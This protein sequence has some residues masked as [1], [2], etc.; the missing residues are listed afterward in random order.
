MEINNLLYSKEVVE[1]SYGYYE[2][3][4]FYGENS[5]SKNRPI[6][7]EVWSNFKLHFNPFIE[8]DLENLT[9]TPTEMLFTDKDV[10]WSTNDVNM[11]I[12]GEDR[13]I[14][15]IDN[16]LDDE[17][18]V[19]FNTGIQLCRDLSIKSGV[20]HSFTIGF[21]PKDIGRPGHHNVLR[22]HAHLR[23][24]DYSMDVD[25]IRK[26]NWQN[27]S[28]VDRVTFQ[29]PFTGVY[30][31]FIREFLRKRNFYFFDPEQM[32]MSEGVILMPIR[33]FDKDNLF[34]AIKLLYR[35]LKTEYN[36][37]HNIYT[38]D[39]ID[40]ETNRY[41]PLE[42]IE[43]QKKLNQFL[44]TDNIYS[45]KSHA[46]LKYLADHMRKASLQPNNRDNYFQDASHLYIDKGFAGAIVISYDRE[47]DGYI[48][49]FLPRV[50]T[51][52]AVSKTMF[53]I[54]K[55]TIMG[56]HKQAKNEQKD[57]INKYKQ[58]ILMNVLELGFPI[59]SIKSNLYELA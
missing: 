57:S 49:Q 20:N 42:K 59:S 58:S 54:D 23:A 32:T 50:L 16:L 44:E 37:I 3:P 8:I 28:L 1:K 41:L 21:N 13:Q 11:W 14:S 43:R 26:A 4:A 56:E 34:G 35:S 31:D 29:E 9:A 2:R 15:E 10:A 30:F 47:V 48:L 51:F 22:L 38:N 7:S 40:P 12:G 52:S 55:P 33:N 36:T 45:D 27:M 24:Y 18:T 46:L 5:R 53:G 39:S 6:S 19:F 25:T 17:G